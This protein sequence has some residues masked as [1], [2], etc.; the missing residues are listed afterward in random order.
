MG[1]STSIAAASITSIQYI[2][3]TAR[4][5]SPIRC[6]SRGEYTGYCGKVYLALTIAKVPCSSKGVV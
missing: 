4:Y 3:E 1:C 2:I 6:C 5:N